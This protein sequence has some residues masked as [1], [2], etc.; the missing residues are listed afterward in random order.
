MNE[1]ILDNEN[2]FTL[3]IEYSDQEVRTRIASFIVKGIQF[4]L[5]KLDL[6]SED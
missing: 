3:L 4:A 5:Q 2:M 1:I 6:Q